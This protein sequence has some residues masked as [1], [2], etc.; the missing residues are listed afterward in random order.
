MYVVDGGDEKLCVSSGCQVGG[1][2]TVFCD[3]GSQTGDTIK[4]LLQGTERYLT[5]CEIFA[6][7]VKIE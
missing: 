7:G 5:M 3:G 6:Y 4:V 2:V 1:E